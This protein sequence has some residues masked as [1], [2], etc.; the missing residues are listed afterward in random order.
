[1]GP[2]DGIEAIVE[3]GLRVGY[4]HLDL[5]EIYSTGPAV[6]RALAASGVP[7]REVWLT[8]KLDGL[9]CGDYAEVKARVQAMLAK[10]HG[11]QGAGELGGEEGGHYFDLLLIHYPLP[12]GR[13]LATEDPATMS[14]AEDFEWFQSNIREAWKNMVHL[15]RDGLVE[16]IGVSNFYSQHI[17]VLDALV[18]DLGED[19]VP[20]FANQLFIDAAH[21]EKDL[22]EQLTRTGVAVLAYRPLAFMPN[23]VIVEEISGPV[24]EALAAAGEGLTALQ[25][26]VLEWL[27][28]R[29]ITPVCSSANEAH[30]EG[31][32]A[33][34]AKGT[35]MGGTADVPGGAPSPVFAAIEVLAATLQSSPAADMVAMIGAVDEYAQAFRQQM[36]SGASG[37]S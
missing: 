24:S 21:P 33:A 36:A 27:A 23:Y 31:N 3:A 14:R 19:G 29:G 22:V 12:R 16:R 10:V 26:L 32:L 2:E 8:S 28:A 9:P 5:A 7:R 13:D 6:G 11:E 20:V 30:L 15:H 4:R 25:P 34:C 37:S 18:R 35:G 1:M 17:E